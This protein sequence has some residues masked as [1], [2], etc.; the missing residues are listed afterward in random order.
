MDYRVVFDISQGYQW[1]P[2]LLTAFGV[3]GGA[4]L[5]LG[6]C[7]LTRSHHPNRNLQML[8]VGAVLLFSSLFAVDSFATTYPAYR[9]Y[10]DLLATDRAAV[11]EGLITDFRPEPWQG[12]APPEQFTVNGVTFEYSYFEMTQGF[13]TTAARG[14]PL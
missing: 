6:Y 13:H 3:I 12:H 9:E 10:D 11:V 8:A 14:G 5:L 4:L 7:F 2:F 1:P